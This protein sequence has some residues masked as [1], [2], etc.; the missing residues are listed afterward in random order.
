MNRVKIIYSCNDFVIA[1]KTHNLATAPLSE[2]DTETA[3]NA[4]LQLFPEGR[5]VSGKK[6]VEYGLV[7]RLDTATHGL[8]LVALNQAAFDNLWAQ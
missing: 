2:N 6:T 4:V 5:N 3:L 8:F 1:E 7:H